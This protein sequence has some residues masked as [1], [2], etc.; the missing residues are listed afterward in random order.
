GGGSGARGGGGGDGVLEGGRL[1]L[2]G[3]WQALSEARTPAAWWKTLYATDWVVYSKP[4]FGGPEQVLKYLACYTHR[5]ALSNSRLESLEYGRVTF[6]YPAYAA[7][8]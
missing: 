2:P 5:V 8:G 1:L 3:R 4:P 7:G 6:R